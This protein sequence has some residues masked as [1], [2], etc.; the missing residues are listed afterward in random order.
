M[1]DAV[2]AQCRVPLQV[3][4]RERFFE[5]VDIQAF[6]LVCELRRRAEIPA[7]RQV[8]GH[9]P[10]LIGI[11]H[12]LE[13]GSHGLAYGFDDGKIDAPILRVEP[14]LQGAYAGTTQRDGTLG[15]LLRRDELTRRR[16]G[17]DAVALASQQA[18]QRGLVRAPTE[19][20]DR[21]LQYP[22]AAVVEVDGLE[23]PVDVRALGVGADEQALEQRLVGKAVA[24]RV[25][26][27]SVVRAHD[28]DGRVLMRARHRVPCGRERRV[29]RVAV[30]PRLDRGDS[31]QSPL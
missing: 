3:V 28:H 26:L 13:V 30:D 7:R 18:P 21:D 6:Q 1:R 8:T 25:A 22:V 17:A 19:V 20:P 24:A 10:S 16:I 29:E 4:R 15:A 14:E 11:D 9:S 2:P 5:P 27:D 23:D 12:D 31:H